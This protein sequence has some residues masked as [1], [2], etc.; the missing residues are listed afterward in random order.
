[1]SVYSLADLLN[2]Q[3]MGKLTASY[4]NDECTYTFN[5]TDAELERVNNAI[6]NAQLVLDTGIE[7][8]T[9]LLIAVEIHCKDDIAGGAKH[10]ALWLLKELIQTLR[11]A[12]EQAVLLDKAV[13]NQRT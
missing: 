11:V 12:N 1:M 8:I 6:G 13:S 10:G 5:G 3:D 4:A 2:L 9:D 7:S